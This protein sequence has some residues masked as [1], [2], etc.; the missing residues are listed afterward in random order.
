M[1]RRRSLP[2]LWR[3]VTKVPPAPRSEFLE[4]RQALPSHASAG[5]ASAG[6]GAGGGGGR[7]F[8]QRLALGRVCVSS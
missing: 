6:R 1:R 4:G 7:V 2:L 3:H 5:S 8:V